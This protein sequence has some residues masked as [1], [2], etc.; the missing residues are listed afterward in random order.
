M[1]VH[2][3]L[4]RSPHSTQVVIVASNLV[5][6]AGD[7]AIIDD[8][9][10]SYTECSGVQRNIPK[11]DRTDGS[12]IVNSRVPLNRPVSVNEEGASAEL[13]SQVRVHLTHAYGG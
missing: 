1:F 6:L 2:I 4:I 5:S 7:S 10:V 13:C 3:A 12:T 9:R 8:E 11:G